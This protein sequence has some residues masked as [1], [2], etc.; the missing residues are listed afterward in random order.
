MGIYFLIRALAAALRC[1][2]RSMF[3]WWP[4]QFISSKS[5]AAQLSRAS[6]KPL[7]AITAVSTDKSRDESEFAR[8]VSEANRLDL[9]LVKFK[10]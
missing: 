6:G 4:G 3:K 5:A 9:Y 10:I 1:F 8:M 7:K 2:H